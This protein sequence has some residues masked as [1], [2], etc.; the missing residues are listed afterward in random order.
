[1]TTVEERI[2]ILKM[3][4]NGQVSATEAVELLAVLDRATDG[5]RAGTPASRS[6]APGRMRVVVSDLGTGQQKVDISL[7]WGLVSVG[8]TMGARFTPPDVDLDLESIMAA[9]QAGT[10][11]KVLE[12]I[13][14]DEGERVEIFVD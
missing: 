3:V 7:P 10:E 12:V 4:E 6:H 8:M 13:D 14:E 5:G 9:V 1:M 2:Q 11:G